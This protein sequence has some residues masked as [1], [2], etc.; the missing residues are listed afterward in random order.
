MRK[1]FSKIVLAAGISLALAFTFGCSSGG[2]ETSNGNGQKPLYNYCVFISSEI[3]LSGPFSECEGGGSPSNTCPFNS[4]NQ[5]SSSSSNGGVS[6]SSSSSSAVPL[7]SST[8]PSSSSSIQY[9]V[10]YGTPI[11]YEGETYQTVVIGEQTWFQ[12]NLNYAVPGSKCGDSNKLL[13]DANTTTCDTY[14]RLYKWATAMAL[15]SNCNTSNCS[16][17]ISEKHKGICPSGWHIPSNNDWNELVN[18]VESSN[19]CSDCAARYLKATSGWDWN[20]YEGKSGNG[21]D[22]YG[23]SALPGSCGDTGVIGR[24]GLEGFWW[25]SNY[26]G[27]LRLHKSYDDFLL[28]Y[29]SEY[30]SYYFFSVRCV[31]N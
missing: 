5:A 19:G 22:R 26:Y 31:Q 11:T 6:S 16:S 28:R 30:E 18:Y 12:R 4:S 23:F 15:P 29:H 10:V 24:V 9:E 13:I 25:S 2:E 8:N 14:G 3:C 21:N 17:Q 20:D 27:Y 7:S 1:L